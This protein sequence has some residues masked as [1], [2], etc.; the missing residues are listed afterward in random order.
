MAF[1][2]HS[3]GSHGEPQWLSEH[4]RQVADSAKRFGENI[5][6]DLRQAAEVSGL[7]H[8]LGKYAAEFQSRLN[9]TNPKRVVHALQGATWAVTESRNAIDV[10]MVI[11]GH[12]A[13][14]PSLSEFKQKVGQFPV[15][16]FWDEAVRDLPE[17][18]SLVMPTMPAALKDKLK[19][20]VWIRL[21][22]SCLVDA[23]FLDTERHF[24]PDRASL[25]VE[26]ELRPN[27]RLARCV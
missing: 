6:K 2:A 11:A 21:L 12:H 4:L 24:E 19:A 23:D 7:L 20:D 3:A 26:S 8:D 14:I 10:G 17:L 22:F 27:E 25:R 1:H 5:T 18:A 9:G 13:G 16:K 15:E